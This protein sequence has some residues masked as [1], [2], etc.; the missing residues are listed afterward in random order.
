MPSG[1]PNRKRRGRCTAAPPIPR[2]LAEAL[3]ARAFYLD[4]LGGLFYSGALYGNLEHTVL[5]SGMNLALVG[6]LRQ[7]HAAAEGTVAALPDVV[8]PV[9]FVLGD[10]VLAGDGQ[11]PVLQG[12]VHVLQLDARK[13]GANHHVPVLGE[14]IYRRGPFGELLASLAPPPAAQAPQHLVEEAIHFTLHVVNPTKR[15]NQNTQTP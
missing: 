8:T 12:D 7:R 11:N 9:L 14:H 10:L 13:L 3:A 15:P 4:S 6:A 5:E 1:R 2:L